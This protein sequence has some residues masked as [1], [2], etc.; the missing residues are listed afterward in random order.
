MARISTIGRLEMANLDHPPFAEHGWCRFTRL[1]VEISGGWSNGDTFMGSGILVRQGGGA[2]A[3]GT[4]QPITSVLGS[5]DYP[6]SFLG[7]LETVETIGGV[8]QPGS[9]TM[10]VEVDKD[11]NGKAE[12]IGPSM[13]VVFDVAAYEG[14]GSDSS[15]GDSVSGSVSCL[16]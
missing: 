3:A 11:G 16:K 10:R 8:P 14:S 12:A 4:F 7:T 9:A 15:G 5:A 6:C 13:S 2:A 1:D